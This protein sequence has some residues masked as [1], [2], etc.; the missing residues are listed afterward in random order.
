MPGYQRTTFKK[1]FQKHGVRSRSAYSRGAA[2]SR[3]QRSWRS[4]GRVGARR[5]KQVIRSTL[6]TDYFQETFTMTPQSG[7]GGNTLRG[8]MAV[9]FTIANT[10]GKRTGDKLFFKGLTIKWSVHCSRAYDAAHTPG[11]VRFGLIEARGTQLADQSLYLYNPTN[12]AAGVNDTDAIMNHAKV[13]VIFD[14]TITMGDS[15]S[16]SEMGYRDHQNVK[17]F[18]K[19]NSRR[20]FISNDVTDPTRVTNKNWYVFAV[21]S[22]YGAGEIRITCDSSFSFKDLA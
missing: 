20:M 10:T 7:A 11:K 21:A 5:I 6:P 15:N 16:W 22:G 14:R 19:C 1:G 9:P 13:R 2:A 12:A 17:T 4:R 18:T 8:M 3:I